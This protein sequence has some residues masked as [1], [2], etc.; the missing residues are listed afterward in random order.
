[1]G[2]EGVCLAQLG[3][4]QGEARRWN[5]LLL[6]GRGRQQQRRRS[7]QLHTQRSMR[8][9][10]NPRFS[11]IY[12]TP[13]PASSTPRRPPAGAW[14]AV[15]GLGLGWAALSSSEPR[16]PAAFQRTFQDA[17]AWFGSSGRGTS[18][19][20]ASSAG[21]AQLMPVPPCA[22]R[23]CAP[24]RCV[25]SRCL[26]TTTRLKHISMKRSGYR[27]HRPQC[28]LPDSTQ[29]AC[30]PVP[31]MQA[32]PLPTLRLELLQ[33]EVAAHAGHLRCRLWAEHAQQLG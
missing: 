27:R 26:P 8:G 21:R 15:V 31:G 28:C 22:Q 19:N 24:Q 18:H 1:M 12:S 10:S 32:A 23:P 2:L 9:I 33:D 30:A 5:S 20:C 7:H 14:A 3:W 29:G 25:L 4:W 13:L 17:G 6:R 16:R 11:K